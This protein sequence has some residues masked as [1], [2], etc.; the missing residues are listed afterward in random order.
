VEEGG[1]QEASPKASPPRNNGALAGGPR[2]LPARSAAQMA[3]AHVTLMQ[4]TAL[5]AAASVLRLRR[6]H[7]DTAMQFEHVPSSATA[8]STM[9]HAHMLQMQV[10]TLRVTA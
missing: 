6:L 5:R 2:D 4:S 8:S 1:A 10:G 3:R 7:G 9:P